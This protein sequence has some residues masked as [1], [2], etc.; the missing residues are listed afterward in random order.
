M[1]FIIEKKKN[2]FKIKYINIFY[3]FK[4]LFLYLELGKKSFL[5]IQ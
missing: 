4:I 3:I 2:L 1:L 5:M